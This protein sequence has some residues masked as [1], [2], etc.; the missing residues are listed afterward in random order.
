MADGIF[1][2]GLYQTVDKK[3]ILNEDGN[4][5]VRWRLISRALYDLAK[6]DLNLKSWSP[7]AYFKPQIRKL[8][9]E[10]RAKLKL[11][12]SKQERKNIRQQYI[13][14]IKQLRQQ[15]KSVK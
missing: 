6:D 15:F 3:K 1:H 2:L 8:K 11:A 13:Q 10:M 5:N 14:K 7:K 4:K 12:K 9:S